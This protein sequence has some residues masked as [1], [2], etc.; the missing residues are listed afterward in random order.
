MKL[1]SETSVIERSGDF[2]ESSFNIEMNSK[3]FYVLSAQLYSNKIQA[4]IRELS[5]NAH[6]AQ[7]FN[8]A[9][10]PFE[11]HLPTVFA[12]EF[13]VRD[14]GPGLAEDDVQNLY[15][16]Y[17]KSS[18]IDSNDFVGCL[19][20]GSKSPFAYT[21]SFTVTSW[22]EGECKTYTMYLDERKF[23]KCAL[24]TQSPSNEPTGLKVSLSVKNNDTHKFMDEAVRIYSFFK[25]A[26]KF[27]GGRPNLKS[28]KGT[29]EG[30]DWKFGVSHGFGSGG[31]MAV[32]GNIAYPI[33][34]A[35]NHVKQHLKKLCSA[36]V[37]IYVG[38]G[39]IEPAPSRE[40]VSYT[41]ET[42][43]SINDKLELV[44]AELLKTA[45]NAISACKNLFEAR[46]A[47]EKLQGDGTF[48]YVD[49]TLVTYKGQ[50]VSSLDCHI[51]KQQF[52]V[53]EYSMYGSKC[54][55]MTIVRI[56]T[57]LTDEYYWNDDEKAHKNLLAHVKSKA[58]RYSYSRRN[59]VYVIRPAI[60]PSTQPPQYDA[61]GNEIKVPVVRTTNTQAEFEVLLGKDIKLISS[62]PKAAPVARR[63]RNKYKIKRLELTTGKIDEL[64]D[65]I[66]D[67]EYYLYTNRNGDLNQ[68]NVSESYWTD[69][70][71][72][73]NIVSLWNKLFPKNA[74]S[75]RILL[76]KK[77]T[78]EPKT[79]KYKLVN[80]H[81]YMLAAL[82]AFT[83]D[84]NNKDLIAECLYFAESGYNS[85]NVNERNLFELVTDSNFK[86]S[87][88]PI[89]TK[90]ADSCK[91][92]VNMKQYAQF[93]KD[94]FDSLTTGTKKPNLDFSQAM[95]AYP[96]LNYL[97]DRYHPFSSWDAVKKQVVLDYLK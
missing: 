48:T 56:G 33:A 82:T 36:N 10:R 78:D 80:L 20:L 11:V 74:I 68:T 73:L 32:M 30:K 92:L 29:L 96:I 58:Q 27:V 81:S 50:K 52:E 90:I 84:K 63:P 41:K 67:G 12:P 77:H 71:K 83:K 85:N 8:K 9:T 89:I 22:F 4:V 69:D 75:N 53:T 42:I 47:Y 94:C 39:D 46:F 59:K 91:D 3:A 70:R 86:G 25:D 66:T 24:L 40:E 7:I 34:S 6:D 31:A 76:L 5:T 44:S 45:Q 17:F 21:D 18:K 16:T 95:T 1:A 28:I 54:Q 62:L 57:S 72:L 60:I 19:G 49:G 15:T 88:N 14:F 35:A 65:T 13:S 51:P 38:I 26:P 55:N 97:F 37:V 79:R 64:E 43:Q 93:I 2:K 61:N 23:P 87:S